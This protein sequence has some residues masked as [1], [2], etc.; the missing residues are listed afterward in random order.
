MIR[1]VFRAAGDQA[2][3]ETPMAP[4]PIITAPPTAV[5]GIAITAASGTPNRSIQSAAGVPLP[6]STDPTAATMNSNQW[7]QRA[8]A[9]AAIPTKRAAPGAT[10]MSAMTT[11]PGASASVWCR[12]HNV[13]QGPNNP[14]SDTAPKTYVTHTRTRKPVAPSEPMEAATIEATTVPASAH[15]PHG[16]RASRRPD[17]DVVAIV[18]SPIAIS[19]DADAAIGVGS[20][21]NAAVPATTATIDRDPMA[22]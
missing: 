16:A 11:G 7:V 6:Y 13:S 12:V 3:A 10:A 21:R 2:S 4:I 9:L 15:L 5:C 20:A 8:P 18:R 1:V 14:T 19:H 17:N 22:I